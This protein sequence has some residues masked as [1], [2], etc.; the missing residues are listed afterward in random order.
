[1]PDKLRTRYRKSKDTVAFQVRR[2]ADTLTSEKS[3][4]SLEIPARERAEEPMKE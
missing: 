3:N 4:S 2:G 1:M